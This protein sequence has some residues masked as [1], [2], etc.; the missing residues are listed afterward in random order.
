MMVIQGHGDR[1]CN[2]QS[3]LAD[4]QRERLGALLAE[5]LPRNAFYAH[6][7]VAAGLSPGHGPAPADLA[8]LPFTTKAEL[9]AEQAAHPP[10][11][12]VLTYPLTRYCRLHQTSGTAGRPLRWLDTS[13]SWQWLLGCWEAYYRIVGLCPGDRLFIA[14]SFGPFLGFWTAFESAVRLGYLCL[15]GG[16]M[17][18]AARLRA[19]VDNEVT[20]VLCTP[21]YALRLAEVA[22]QEGIDLAR[23]PVRA[24]IVAGEPGGC[25]PATRDRIEAAWGARVFDHYGMTEVGAVGIEC[26]ENPAGLHLLETDYVVEVIDPDTEKAVAPGQ[27]GELVLT[28]LGR[29]GSP[30]LRYRTGDLVRI[31]SQPCPC[32]RPFVRLSGGI[33]GR[34]DD[35]IH[36]RGNKLYPGALEAIIRRFSEVAEYRMQVDR[37]GALAELLVEIEPVPSAS[38]TDLA[39]RVGRA[40][41][42]E[43]LF[44]AEVRAVAPGSLPRFEM[45]AR[46]LVRRGEGAVSAHSH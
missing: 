39:E 18:S 15:P 24:L 17:S 36:L 2:D 25:I 35:M 3:A 19:L 27:L 4:Q 6:K 11:G 42:A 41:G 5:I 23:S 31:D 33:L 14:F 46:R 34:V 32:G 13:E 16:G 1:A 8:R 38:G 20:V 40:I 26:L 30:V 37:S 9:L 21:T 43:L 29:W 22:A 44:R 10:Y 28:N 7:F 45:K 12:R